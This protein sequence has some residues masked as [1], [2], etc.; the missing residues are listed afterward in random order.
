VGVT[1]AL[2][3]TLRVG[4]AE[5]KATAQ[6]IQLQF[7]IFAACW[8]LI[9]VVFFSISRSKLPGYILPAIPGGVFL[10]ADYLL[11]HREQGA[12][13]PRWLALLHAVVACA[14]IV[15]A[16]VIGYLVMQH[17]LPGGTPMY[18][19]LVLALIV[20]AGIAITLS[21]RMQL[22][23]FRFVTLIP[24]LLAVAAVLKFGTVAIDQK[25]SARPLALELSSIE[26]K[27]LPIAVDGVQRELEYGLAFYR[28]QPVHR[29]E[30]GDI[31]SGEHLLVAPTTWMADVSQATAGRR[32]SLLGHYAPQAVDYYWVAATGTQP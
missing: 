32:V 18:F 3:E 25:L 13:L 7:R 28:N 14:P 9:P 2:V 26:T 12:A 16:V 20:C 30:S 19:A 11:S 5:R 24:A 23:M 8:L 10:L 22:R 15:P 31:P 27:K 21:G 29:Y 4:W 17:R 1:V 6:D